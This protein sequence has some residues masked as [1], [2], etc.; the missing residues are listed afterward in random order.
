M[1]S[2]YIRGHTKQFSRINI[3]LSYFNL[4][5]D[6]QIILPLTL[7]LYDFRLLPIKFHKLVD[8]PRQAQI[9]PDQLKQIVKRQ[10]TYL[11]GKPTYSFIRLKRM[12]PF[13][14]NLC[15]MRIWVRF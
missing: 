12:I 4:L 6:S 1:T 11:A 2:K 14:M 3:A 15:L 5:Q 8:I 13:S 10:T 9:I 7:V